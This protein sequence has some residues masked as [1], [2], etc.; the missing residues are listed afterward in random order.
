[1]VTDPADQTSTLT[2]LVSSSTSHM[3]QQMISNRDIISDL[4]SRYIRLLES[5]IA[6]LES[7][8]EFGKPEPDIPDDVCPSFSLFGFD[9]FLR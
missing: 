2:P 6:N 5:K 9:Y 8:L 3:E 4:E 1:M 7:Q